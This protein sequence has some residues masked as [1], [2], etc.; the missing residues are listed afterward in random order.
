VEKEIEKQNL[1]LKKRKTTEIEEKNKK[2]GKKSHRPASPRGKKKIPM[3]TREKASR[4]HA[5]KK[6]KALTLKSW[7]N[8][9]ERGEKT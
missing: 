5:K 1:T 7:S 3:P 2:F 4:R 8:S 6:R 9:R